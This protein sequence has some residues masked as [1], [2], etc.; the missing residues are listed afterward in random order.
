MPLP[1]RAVPLLA[2]KT[3]ISRSRGIVALCRASGDQGRCNE[4][5]FRCYPSYIPIAR[6]KVLTC[7]NHSITIAEFIESR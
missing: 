4:D 6:I 1:A 7:S 2:Y 3:K 5:G